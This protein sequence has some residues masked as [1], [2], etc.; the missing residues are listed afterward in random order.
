PVLEPL[1][2]HFGCK[3]IRSCLQSLRIGDGQ[4][5]VVVLTEAYLLAVEFLLDEVVAVQIVGG[6]KGKERGHAY[7][8][9]PQRFVADVE[10][11][12]RET[13][14]LAGQDA[15]VGIVGGKAGNRG[16]ESLALLHAFQ[17][18]VHTMLP[19]PFHAAQGGTNIIL[20]AH[21][22][23]S[24]LDGGV[25]ARKRL[26]PS[27]ILVGPARQYFLAD[28]RLAD[29]VLK[30]MNHLP[31]PGK[32]AQ[33]TVD[34]HSV[35]TVVYKQKQAAKQPC[36]CLHRS[37]SCVLVSTTRSSDRR[38]AEANFKYLWLGFSYVFRIS[39]R[40]EPSL[41][42][43]PR[44]GSLLPQIEDA[45]THLTWIQSQLCRCKVGIR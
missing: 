39:A 20:L 35:K 10:V 22:R 27:L 38:P 42:P 9:R 13:A 6:L 17:N 4:E 8:H 44:C 24:P 7:H 3:A 28:H 26:H 33:I 25:V 16:A 43:C 23:L 2:D 34:H 29:H 19:G 18:E 31:W 36:E 41:L 30:E 14:A 5:G 40:K 15:V 11:I 12:V 21:L 1:A 45:L 32:S 37:P